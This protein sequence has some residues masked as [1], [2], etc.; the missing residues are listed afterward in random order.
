MTL[1]QILIIEVTTFWFDADKLY[2]YVDVGQEK[3]L[4]KNQVIALKLNSLL[5]VERLKDD[6]FIARYHFHCDFPLINEQ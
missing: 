1:C 4:D 6:R 2:N 3:M 5:Q